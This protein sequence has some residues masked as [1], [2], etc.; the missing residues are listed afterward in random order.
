MAEDKKGPKGKNTNPKGRGS[1]NSAGKKSIHKKK[2]K[3]NAFKDKQERQKKGD[4]VPSMSEEVRL[5]KYLA[6]AGICSRREADVLIK[7]GVVKVNDKVITELGFKVKPGDKVQYDGETISPDTLR[8]ILLNK[9]KGYTVS[10]SIREK[11]VMYLVS[12]ACKEDIYPID[13]MDRNTTG[14]LLFTNDTD[15][16]K[17]LGHPKFEITK[18]YQISITKPMTAEHLASLKTGIE[19]ED[20]KVW[21]DEAEFVEDNPREI[22][23]EMRSNKRKAAQRMIE[24]LGYEVKKVDRVSYAG[25]TKKDLPRSYWRPLTEKEISFLRMSKKLK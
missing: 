21:A 13:R 17:K 4:P 3:Y 11:S 14:L 7:T 6:N 5:N 22:G 24:S 10:N 1:R 12:K 18:I 16:M 2:R 8:Y 19:L 20:G 25:L 15:L 23:I 9:P